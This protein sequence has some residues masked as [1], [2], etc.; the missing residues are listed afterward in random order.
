LRTSSAFVSLSKAMNTIAQ[1]LLRFGAAIKDPR[2]AHDCLLRSRAPIGLWCKHRARSSKF[3]SP[4]SPNS[5]TS[6]VAVLSASAVQWRDDGVGAPRREEA[7]ALVADAL[8]GRGCPLA[9]AFLFVFDFRL[10]FCR[11][12][13]RHGNERGQ[14]PNRNVAEDA[15]ISCRG[16]MTE[17]RP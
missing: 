16:P 17:R 13:L 2:N 15:G 10:R 11:R 9:A 8:K 4:V 5:F 6:S 12:S 14:R 3:W 7:T 1:V